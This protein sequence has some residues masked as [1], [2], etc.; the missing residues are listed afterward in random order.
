MLE[1]IHYRAHQV[2]SGKKYY[3]R[4]KP[5][6]A[7]LLLAMPNLKQPFHSFNAAEII[8]SYNYLWADSNYFLAAKQSAQ[9]AKF[10]VKPEVKPKQLGKLLGFSNERDIYQRLIDLACIPYFS[11]F[12]ALRMALRYFE[13]ASYISDLEAALQYQQRTWNTLQRHQKDEAHRAQRRRK[14]AYGRN[15]KKVWS[16]NAIYSEGGSEG[17]HVQVCQQLL[18]YCSTAVKI[19]LTDNL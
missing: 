14:V 1:E 18:C 11:S 16:R 5:I 12:E 7:M 3:S 13:S 6:L 2:Q 17:D 15:T 8:P 4:E 9:L 10:A 19:R